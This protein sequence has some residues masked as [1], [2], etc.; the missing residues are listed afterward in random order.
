MWIYTLFSQM[1]NMSL[2]A[3]IVIVFVLLARLLLKRA[4]K[5]FSY[6]LWVVV[7]FR[8]LCPVSI[9]SEQSL[10]NALDLS[11]DKTGRVEYIYTENLQANTPA[12]GMSEGVNEKLPQGE[13]RL[14]DNLLGHPMAAATLV[15]LIGMLALLANS[16]LS[17]IKLHRKLIGAV[18]LRNNIYLA[19]HIATPFVIGLL[20]PK[21][22]I[23]STLAEQEQVYIIQH[24]Q[25]HIRRF[26]PIIKILAFAA[27]CAHWFNPLVWL[28]FVLSG[29]DMEMSCDEAV[30][31]SIGGDIRA[32]YS[33]SLLSLATGKR[34]IAGTPLAFGEGNTKDRIKNVM[35]YKK[36]TFWMVIAAALVVVLGCVGL[37]TNPSQKL[38]IDLSF[39]TSDIENIEV[40]Y[41]NVPA[42]AEKKVVT[43]PDDIKAI[44]NTLT[45]IDVKKGS[46]EPVAGS[47]TIGFRFSLSDGSSFEIIHHNYGV[48][49]GEIMSSYVFDYITEADICGLWRNLSYEILD[50]EESELPLYEK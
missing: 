13:E 15:W 6:V 31:K 41:Y 34:I 24:E 12:T 38:K 43:A 26:D 21:I 4:P 10:L 46:Y 17:L 40:F 22:Y 37:F 32:E 1:L 29:K 14:I 39:S 44:Y 16:I 5:I 20:H 35:N 8:L 9:S 49:K 18:H 33:T 11:V 48:K 2:T 36:P 25:Q 28:A 27:L 42:M 50:A 19:D 30:I 47:D 3:S 23:P 7:L 45:S